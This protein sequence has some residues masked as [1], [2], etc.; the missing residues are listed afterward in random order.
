MEGLNP[1]S[2][3]KELGFWIQDIKDIR[4]WAVGRKVALAAMTALSWTNGQVSKQGKKKVFK[5]QKAEG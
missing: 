2:H 5:Q 3:K 1:K 4:Y